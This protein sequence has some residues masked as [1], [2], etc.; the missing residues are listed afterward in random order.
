MRHRSAFSASLD[1]PDRG[2]AHIRCSAKRELRKTCLTTAPERLVGVAS[3]RKRI[4]SEKRADPGPEADHGSHFVS[5]P[6]FEHF[7]GR[8]TLTRC[9]FLRHFQLNPSKAKMLTKR[10]LGWRRHE[11]A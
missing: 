1:P 6:A 10:P 4:P 11:C 8:A 5:L 2:G 9:D 7:S 3:N